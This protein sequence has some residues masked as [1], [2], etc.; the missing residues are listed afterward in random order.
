[1]NLEPVD[2]KKSVMRFLES[3]LFILL[4]VLYLACISNVCSRFL[5][6]R[7]KACFRVKEKQ[8]LKV[9]LKNRLAL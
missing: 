1:M 4:C 5:P 7:R 2:K 6:C 8:K 9:S 3:E